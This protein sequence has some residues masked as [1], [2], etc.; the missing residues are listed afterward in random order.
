MPKRFVV[1]GGGSFRTFK[2]QVSSR[3]THA[4]R[5]ASE[6]QANVNRPMV[7]SFP[8][9]FPT[10]PPAPYR[11]YSGRVGVGCQRHCKTYRSPRDL[12]NQGIIFS[13]F[14]GRSFVRGGESSLR[15]RRMIASRSV[16]GEASTRQ[17][18]STPIAVS[19]SSHAG[20]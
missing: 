7:L 15:T 12:D 13:H 14:C 4:D 9:L 6:Q 16:Y 17:V 1:E 11:S 3:Q 19:G 8:L 18:H 20:K 10:P 5:T 2:V